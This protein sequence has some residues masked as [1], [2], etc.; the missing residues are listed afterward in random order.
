MSVVGKIAEIHRYPVKSMRGE[1]LTSCDIGPLGL[2]GDRGWAVRDEKSGEIRGAKNFPKLMTC[3]AR[4]SEEPGPTH[5]PVATITL[6]GGQSLP[7][8]S[9]DANQHLSEFL[10]REVTLHP[11]RPKED[12][13]HYRRT[14][15]LDETTLRELLGRRPEDPMPD[16]ST[17]PEEVMAELMEFT[18]PRGTYFDAFPVQLLTTSWLDHLRK[19]APESEFEVGRFRPNFLVDEA[20]P[21]LAEEKW[22]G[23]ILRIGSVEIKCEV[24]TVRCSMTTRAT[25][26]LPDDRNVL[27][28]ILRVSGQN[29]GAYATVIKAGRISVGDLVELS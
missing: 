16:L 15:A 7:A 8:D 21:G 23:K 20:E 3:E 13:D 9:D 26:S 4:Y 10:G 14:Q 18:S 5:I 24:P 17:M 11:L 1:A 2:W 12:S 19:E 27:K 6:P 22:C 25:G 29:A 28:T